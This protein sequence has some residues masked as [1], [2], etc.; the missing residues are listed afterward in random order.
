VSQIEQPVDAPSSDE[1]FQHDLLIPSGHH[2]EDNVRVHAYEDV[3][4]PGFEQSKVDSLGAGQGLLAYYPLLR[5]LTRLGEVEFVTR[6]GIIG[7][8]ASSEKTRWAHDELFNHF[9]WLTEGE[10]HRAFRGLRKSGWLKFTH[11][12]YVLSEGGEAVFTMLSALLG[13][14]PS[15]GD[16]ALGVIEVE[17]A[18]QLGTDQSVSL[19][20]LQHNLRKVITEAEEALTSYSEVKILEARDRMDR[21]LAWSMRAREILEKLDVSKYDDY[22]TA[23]GIGRSLSELHQWQGTLQR[24]LNDIVRQRIHLGESGLS[25]TDITHFLMKCSLDE[26]ATFGERFVSHPVAPKFA[27]VDNMLTL[28]EDYLY[29]HE[30]EDDEE[31]QGWRQGD[32]RTAE[33]GEISVEKFAALARFAGDLE[34]LKESGEPSSLASFVPAPTWAESAYRMSMLTLVEQDAPVTAG[35]ST[36]MAA[37]MEKVRD[38]PITMKAKN[39]GIYVNLEGISEISVGTVTVTESEENLEE[40]A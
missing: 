5:E 37:L 40:K 14:A 8:L 38:C 1:T 26:L 27:S 9:P 21:N 7:E 35:L 15:E 19:R 20:H 2:E 29:F 17:M 25:L 10:R 31:Q 22:K 33:K 4:A 3:L 36:A 11:N 18:N 32:A 24:A 13:M 12:G 6:V 39:E 28:A 30:R 16:I 23:Q 34:S